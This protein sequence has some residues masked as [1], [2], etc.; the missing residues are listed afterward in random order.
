MNEEIV[1]KALLK[2]LTVSAEPKNSKLTSCAIVTMK[3]CHD[4]HSKTI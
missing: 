3:T 1:N 2:F 4:N